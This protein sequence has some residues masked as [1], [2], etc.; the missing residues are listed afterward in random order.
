M[1]RTGS[2]KYS[3]TTSTGAPPAAYGYDSNG[4]L[5]S[6]GSTSFV[7][8][9]ENRLVSASGAKTAALAYD[10]LGRLFQVSGGAAPLQFL[11]DGDALIGEYDGPDT[12]PRVYIHAVGA[13]VPFIWFEGSSAG[14][15]LYADHQGSIVAAAHPNNGFLAI[16]SY[17]AWGIPAAG[18]QGRFGYTG[19]AWIPEL[20]MWYYKAR[21][22]SPTT[23]RFMQVDPIGYDDQLNLYGY[24][25]NDPVN[26]TDPS[27]MFRAGSCDP[28]KNGSVSAS[29]SGGSVLDAADTHAA[30][31]AHSPREYG[32]GGRGPKEGRANSR[33]GIGHNRPPNDPPPARP[34]YHYS[35]LGSLA[36]AILS[37]GGD[38]CKICDLSLGSVLENP[39]SLNGLT[40]DQVHSR[41]G[42]PDGWVWTRSFRGDNAGKGWALR[43]WGGR[44]WTGR[45]IRWHPGGGRHGEDPYWRVN[46]SQAKSIEIPSGGQW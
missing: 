10:P 43:E 36:G 25:G 14:R 17:D 46:S 1:R 34:W 45:Q 42:T 35:K 24:V 40:L 13:D 33:P 38:T 20:G 19:Q 27:G 7:Y 39:E 32:P 23:G 11:Y 9:V 18:N 41:L 5:A 2:T 31:V 6:D 29:C 26:S 4:N 44:D 12:R 21:F 3:G 30:R 16:N 37:L 22:Y 8:D 15:G 28:D